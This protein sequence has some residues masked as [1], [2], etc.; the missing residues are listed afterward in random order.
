MPSV[1]LGPLLALVAAAILVAGVALLAVLNPAPQV[2]AFEV[3]I[4]ND[5]FSR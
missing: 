1:P 4:S 2:R 5:R 3:P